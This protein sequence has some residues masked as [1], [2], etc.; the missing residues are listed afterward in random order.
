VGYGLSVAPQNRREVDDVGHISRS[1]GLLHMEA[2]WVRV[3]Q[4]ASSQSLHRDQVEDGRVDAMDYVGPCYP[5]F[6][7]FFVLCL[8][9]NLVL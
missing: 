9:V 5:C 7:V 6:V 3:S 1:N 8:R 4:F 2:S